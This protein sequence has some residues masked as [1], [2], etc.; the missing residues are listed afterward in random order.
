MNDNQ[1]PAPAL[2]TDR[3]LWREQSTLPADPDNYY[4]PSIHVTTSGMIGINVGGSVIVLPL[5]EWHRR[6]SA[7]EA[8]SGDAE[9]IDR[10]TGLRRA[11]R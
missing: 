11:G 4:A 9:H 8:P 7:I 10:K 1:I 5:R 2:N 3:E 6:A